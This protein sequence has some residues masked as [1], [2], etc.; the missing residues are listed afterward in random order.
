MLASIP[1]TL[2]AVGATLECSVAAAAGGRFLHDAAT[3]AKLPSFMR[4]ILA[5]MHIVE[6]HSRPSLLFHHSLF[7]I[8][9]VTFY[10]SE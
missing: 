9:R 8:H 7:T 4:E 6:L 1:P 5:K 3:S 2:C 10:A